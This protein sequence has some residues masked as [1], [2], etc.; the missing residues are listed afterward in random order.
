MMQDLTP[1]AASSAK[2]GRAAASSKKSHVGLGLGS[3]ASSKVLEMCL[4]IFTIFLL[5]H[6]RIQ[7]SYKFNFSNHHQLPGFILVK[8]F[9]Q[10]SK[11]KKK[12]LF[13]DNPS[14]LTM[15]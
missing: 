12:K 6:K 13:Y 2:R 7:R 10:L 14:P 3:P 4:Q 15:P 1:G 11:I 8:P 9:L 5:I